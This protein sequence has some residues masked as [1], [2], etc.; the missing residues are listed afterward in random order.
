MKRAPAV[1]DYVLSGGYLTRIQRIEKK[2]WGTQ[3]YYPGRS[4]MGGWSQ[5]LA[6]ATADCVAYAVI[7]ET[8]CEQPKGEQFCGL[9]HLPAAD[10]ADLRK[11]EGKVAV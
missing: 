5:Y 1:G 10:L 4:D 7:G 9:A 11:A 8:V 3:A 6:H 2:R